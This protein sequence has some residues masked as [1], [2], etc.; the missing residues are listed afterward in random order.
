MKKLLSTKYSANAVNAAMLILRLGLG[1]L[2][3]VKYGFQKITHFS[4]TASHMPNLLGMGGTVNAAL[5]IF[6]E[7]FCS[8][9]LILG[10]FTRLAC[11][12]LII[13]MSVILYRIAHFDFFGQGHLAAL[14]LTGFIAILLIGP[15]KVSVD[16]MMGK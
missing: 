15:G 1:T 10:L 11:I 9:F 8:M 14:Y 3:V 2:M 5:I 13:A 16:G 7:F 6:A 4:D 12:P